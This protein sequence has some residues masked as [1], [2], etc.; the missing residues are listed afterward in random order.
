MYGV[1][2]SGVRQTYFHWNLFQ[3][4][5]SAVLG[6]HVQVAAH[7]T[8]SHDV[9][10]E[11][12]PTPRRLDLLLVLPKVFVDV[13]V[14]QVRGSGRHYDVFRRSTHYLTQGSRQITRCLSGDLRSVEHVRVLVYEELVDSVVS[15]PLKRKVNVVGK[16]ERRDVLVDVVFGDR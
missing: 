6:H 13:Q 12:E 14:L 8:D 15:S 9:R 7:E 16:S 1:T 11:L 4:S 5:A 3:V 10:R 2:L